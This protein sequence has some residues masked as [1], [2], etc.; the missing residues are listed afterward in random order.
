MHDTAMQFGQ[1]FFQTYVKNSNK[2]KILDIG[3]QD[4][5][6]SLRTV[7]PSVCEYIGVDFE[8]ANGVDVVLTD[9]NVLPF[10]NDSIDVVVSSSCFEHA[11]F[12]LVYVY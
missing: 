5:N 1:L 4:V 6:G 11:E 9:A 2:I 12:F 10:D 7:A 8:A 3:S